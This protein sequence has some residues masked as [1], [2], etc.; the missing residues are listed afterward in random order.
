MLLDEEYML[1]ALN[2]AEKA[3]SLGEAPIG[4]I[5]IN[6][7]GDI[8]AEAYNQR[9]E[10]NS[11]LAHAE[12]LAIEKAACVLNSRRLDSCTMYVT[13]EPCLMC[14]GAIM[15]AQIKRVVFGAY[16]PKTGAL[17][18]VASVYDYNF[19]FKPMVRGGILESE[20]ALLLNKFGYFLR[21]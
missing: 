20:C 4:A 10:L 15:Q 5:I 18:S 11:P 6:E 7:N 9:E 2:L 8:I 21:I 14:A 19:G 16:A 13:L 12:L 17:T 1:Q 3:F